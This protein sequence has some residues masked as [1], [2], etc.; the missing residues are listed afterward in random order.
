MMIINVKQTPAHTIQSATV[1]E[2]P[3]KVP[4]LIKKYK[5]PNEYS[6]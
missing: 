2:T 3:Y 5:H 1:K 4:H 6:V